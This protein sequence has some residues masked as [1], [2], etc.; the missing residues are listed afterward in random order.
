MASMVQ[1][2]REE[3]KEREKKRLDTV[4]LQAGG[5]KKNLHN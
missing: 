4:I 2:G 1:R 3:K 5:Y